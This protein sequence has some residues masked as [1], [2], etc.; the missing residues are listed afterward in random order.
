MQ[1]DDT[2][3]RQAHV[4]LRATPGESRRDCR[5]HHCSCIPGNDAAV[6]EARKVGKHYRSILSAEDE[7]I[8]QH[9]AM[10]YISAFGI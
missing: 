9:A 1:G 4:V 8:Y 5:R 2:S 10:T 6:P 3:F 7:E